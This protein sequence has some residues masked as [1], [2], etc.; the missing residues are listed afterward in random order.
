[1]SAAPRGPAGPG[2]PAPP[3][4]AAGPGEAAPLHPL[5]A[6]EREYP[7]VTLDRRRDA[8][9]P[10]GVRVLNFGIG[11]PREETPPFIREALRDAVP[12]MSSYPAA[13][14]R[15]ELRAACA[16]WLARRFGVAADPERDVL[17]AN[18]TKE[19]VFSL[20]LAVVDPAAEKRVVVI[21]TPAYPVYDSGARFAGAEVHGVPLRS[22]D[23]WRFAPERV[24]E[25]V[26][27]RTALLWLNS[28]HNP[29]GA[30]LDLED[31]ARVHALARRHGF[32]I[33][34][35]EAYAEVYFERVPPSMLQVGFDHVLA[36]H[37]LSKRS[38][39][40]G[41]RSGFLCGDPRLVAALRRFRPNLGVATP[42]FVQA[43]AIAAW[44]D[45]AHP[46]DQRARYAVKRRLMLDYFAARGWRVEASE[47]SF[48]LWMRA[49][50]GDDVGFVERV[51]RVGVVAMP[52]SYLGAGGEGFVRW[53]L[54]PT[55]EDCREAIARLEGVA[56]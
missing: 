21:P 4:P 10:P 38:A 35:D 12:V 34:A 37:T 16:A 27:R 41:F 49:P 3:G 29:T 14:G 13:A 42:D 39:M 19:A 51:L 36:F 32:W 9:A 18:G 24:P 15:A 54:V 2:T 5:L 6:G 48:Y 1:M 20:A 45:D 11:D 33:A 56:A 30:T 26:W 52:G 40:T 47:A 8:L 28:P 44:R 53:A 7:F 31:L 23:G 46:A 50:G 25:A 55:P 22:E 43:A 17:P